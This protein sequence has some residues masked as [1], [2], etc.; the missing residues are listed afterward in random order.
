M[1]D[2]LKDSFGDVAIAGGDVV[3]ATSDDKHRADLLLVEKGE[4]KWAPA[5]GVG[6]QNFLEGEDVAGLLREI[7]LQFSADGMTIKELRF[8]DDGRLAINAPYK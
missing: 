8:L 7:N 2:L 3:V 4:L 5:V 1:K 6:A